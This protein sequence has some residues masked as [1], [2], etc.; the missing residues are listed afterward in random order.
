ML[1]ETVAR[2]LAA[3]GITPDDP[4][5]EA[6]R[7]WNREASLRQELRVELRHGQ[8]GQTR[9]VRLDELAGQDAD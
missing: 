3:A 4:G 6:I 7:A 1:A 9:K 5:L 8:F 2:R